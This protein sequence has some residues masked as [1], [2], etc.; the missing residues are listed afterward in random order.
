MCADCLWVTQ[1]RPCNEITAIHSLL[2]RHEMPGTDGP[3]GEALGWFCPPIL[4]RGNRVP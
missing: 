4:L 1:P 3:G 2:T